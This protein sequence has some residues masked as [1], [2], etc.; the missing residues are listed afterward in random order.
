MSI[1][2]YAVPAIGQQSKGL[3]PAIPAADPAK[4]AAIRDARDWKNPYLIVHDGDIEVIA[5][6]IPTPR[7][8]NTSDALAEVLTK[9]PPSA[10][11]YGRVAAIQD[12]SS[13]PKSGKHPNRVI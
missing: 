7:R 2:L 9:L 6:T 5:T 10:W 3:S 13:Q 11:P 12:A 8:V 1:A 4:Y